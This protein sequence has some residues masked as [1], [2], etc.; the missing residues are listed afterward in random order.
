MATTGDTLNIRF[1]QALALPLQHRCEQLAIIFAEYGNKELQMVLPHLLENLFGLTN[2]VGWG[3]RTIYRNSQPR[4]FEILFRFLEP[5]GPIFRL[6]YKLLT[7]SSIKYEFPI[8]Y[9]PVKV[10]K[11]MEDGMIPP[12][13]ADKLQIDP[14][15]RIPTSLV[16][17]I[18]LYLEAL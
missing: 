18:L 10:R 8:A 3:L 12:F 9:L 1:N 2:H 16:L 15:T 14:Q 13:Y 11:S 17:S 7:E 4:E 6:C 5:N